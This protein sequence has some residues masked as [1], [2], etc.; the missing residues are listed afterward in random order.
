MTAWQSYYRMIQFQC[1]ILFFVITWYLILLFLWLLNY[2]FSPVLFFVSCP[3]MFISLCIRI[4]SLSLEP[5]W[6]GFVYILVLNFMQRAWRSF[7]IPI[8]IGLLLVY[9][10]YYI[11]SI[12]LWYAQKIPSTSPSILRTRKMRA[13]RWQTHFVEDDKDLLNCSIN[14]L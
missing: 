14:S 13:I 7:F 5:S 11:M 8:K 6:E 9:L 12:N 10:I 2:T 4:S 1:T 3:P